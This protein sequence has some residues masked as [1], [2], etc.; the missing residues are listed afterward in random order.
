MTIYFSGYVTKKN[1][2]SEILTCTGK[3]KIADEKLSSKEELLAEQILPKLT[4][5]RGNYFCDCDVELKG[6]SVVGINNLEL[7]KL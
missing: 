7:V 2:F 5:G 3:G 4:I 1:G 6:N